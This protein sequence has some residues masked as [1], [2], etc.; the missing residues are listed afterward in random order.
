[1]AVDGARAHIESDVAKCQQTRE[2][3]A[4]V[5]WDC[6]VKTLF[7]PKNYGCKVAVSSALNWFFGIVD[8]GIVLEDDCLPEDSFFSF[9]QELLEKYRTDER[10]MMISGNNFQVD[11]KHSKYSYYFSRYSYIWGWASWRRAWKLYDVDMSA[12]PEIREERF[13]YDI[14]HENNVAFHW[15]K[16]LNNVYN[17][18]VD[19]WDYQFNFAAWIN[20]CLSIVPRENLVSNIGFRSDGTHVKCASMYANVPTKN[21]TFPLAHPPCIIANT[22][23]DQYAEKKMF[24]IQ[25]LNREILRAVGAKSVQLLR[26]ALPG[27]DCQI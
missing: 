8:E 22:L 10:I 11:R 6:E 17:G 12:W 26:K 14:F 16:V 21:V 2:I 15:A 25:S 13:L 7:H 4:E 18:F 5:D 9:C 23:A 1:M 3:A 19:T 24:D 20:N 27:K